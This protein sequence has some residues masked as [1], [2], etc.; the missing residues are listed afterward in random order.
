M[1]TQIKRSHVVIAVVMALAGSTAM[2]QSTAPATT[3]QSSRSSWLPY[4]NDG[5][6]GLN[7]GRSSF[8]NNCIGGFSCDRTDRSAHIY[9]GGYFTPH[10]G[11][12]IGYVDFGDMQRAGGNT[13]AHGLNLSLIA[14]TPLTQ[15]LGLYAKLGTTYG[16]TRVNSA[17]GSGIASGSENGW[18]P[19][20]ALGVS[21]HF[22]PQW[23]AVLEWNRTRFDYAGNTDGWVR[24]TNIGVSYHF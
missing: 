21:W 2:A 16:R 20:Y 9:V 15:N 7:V 6:I 10:F 5:Y 3:T 17:A 24:S 19:A 14:R 18:G 4:T 11:A 12:E 23:S 13:R 1:K 22:T 8:Q